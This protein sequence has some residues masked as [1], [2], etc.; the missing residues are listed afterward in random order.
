MKE[1]TALFFT[2]LEGEVLKGIIAAFNRYEITAH[3]K[4][5]LP[6]TI[7][8]HSIHD[9]RDKK[10][11]CYLKNIQEKSEDWKKSGLYVSTG[12]RGPS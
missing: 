11:R 10:G 4:G 3:M 8:R 5:G 12:V 6:L 7:L 1:R 9:I 2:L